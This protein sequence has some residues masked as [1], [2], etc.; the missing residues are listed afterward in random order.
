MNADAML[1]A[2]IHCDDGETWEFDEALASREQAFLLCRQ[3]QAT[4]ERVEVRTLPARVYEALR[5]E[6]PV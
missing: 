3:L 4:H 5:R 2:V 6:N 1:Y